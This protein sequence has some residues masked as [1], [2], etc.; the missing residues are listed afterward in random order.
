MKH[1]SLHLT[2]DTAKK[3]LEHIV[4]WPDHP[5]EGVLFR[6][7]SMVLADSVSFNMVISTLCTPFMLLDK[8][9]LPACIAGIE[10]RGYIYGAAMAMLLGIAFVPVRKPGKLPEG[11]FDEETYDTEYSKARLQLQHGLVKPGDHV[12]VCDDLIATGGSASAA[13]TLVRRSGGIVESFAFVLEIEACLGRDKLR[14]NDVHA[15]ITF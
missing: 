3:L 10:S 2:T 5:I 9:Q 12:V 15:L 6:D 1:H 14:G 11:T 4:E 13:A 7:L 8:K